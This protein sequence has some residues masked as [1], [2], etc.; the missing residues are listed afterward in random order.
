MRGK[1]L[2]SLIIAAFALLLLMTPVLAIAASGDPCCPD[3]SKAYINPYQ[4]YVYDDTNQP[5]KGALVTVTGP[6]KY[7]VTDY[8]G[9]KGKTTVYTGAN[10]PGTYK[11]TVEKEGYEQ[12]EESLTFTTSE[13]SCEALVIPIGLKLKPCE[14]SIKVYVYDTDT[15]SPIN[16]ATVTLNGPS[17]Q[18][19]DLTDSSGWTKVFDDLKIGAYTAS[20][21][22][23]GYDGPGSG[24]AT[25][26][27]N[28]CGQVIIRIGLKASTCERSIKV[29]VYDV[30]T[31]SPIN[32]ATVTL[33]GPSFQD[34][35]LT[36]LSGWTKVFDDLKIGAYTAS[37]TADG[38][39]GPGSG[40][41]TF[42]VNNCGQVVIRIGLSVSCERSLQ[43]YVFNS[44]TNKP[45]PNAA[46]NIS[47]PNSFNK[48][49]VTDAGGKYILN[50]K[51]N[52]GTYTAK[53]T[54]K[55][56]AKGTGSVTFTKGVC[57]QLVINIGLK[58]C[59]SD[60]Q[61]KNTFQAYVYDTDNN[62]ING[63]SVTISGPGS[64]KVAD[65]TGKK[66]TTGILSGANLPGTYVITANKSGYA[67]G[68]ESFIITD[69]NCGAH[70]IKI[71]L[72]NL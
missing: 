12:A 7:K 8:T 39:D 60:C 50:D 17:F 2:F 29:Y 70:L 49:G 10:L 33:N 14:R 57:G 62:P 58:D 51:L 21:T 55:D 42:E 47:G 18:D 63:A 71:Q 22:A 44:A 4:V 28:N 24:T 64:Y 67:S 30:D 20:A 46:I 68:E 31:N 35:D 25:F 45:V 54:A 27:V 23:D 38:Y 59:C 13:Y 11:I 69:K 48:L 1:K 43:V 72:Q 53:I 52:N 16:E 6:C 3:G 66:G 61:C 65:Y 40:T 19:S 56:F 32:E 15:N 41:A 5:V 37:A 26:E 36:D 9:K 34:S